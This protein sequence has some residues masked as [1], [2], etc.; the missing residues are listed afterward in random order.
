[1]NN[2]AESIPGIDH[3]DQFEEALKKRLDARLS[4]LATH[5]AAVIVR[6]Y[7]DLLSDYREMGMPWEV[8]AEELAA[9]GCLITAQSLRTTF[10]RAKKAAGQRARLAVVS[11]NIAP[12]APPAQSGGGQG[13]V[14]A[15]AKVPATPSSPVADPQ[16]EGAQAV[17]HELSEKEK[18]DLIFETIPPPDREW[19]ELVNLRLWKDE[20]GKTWDVVK[21]DRN[22][23]TDLGFKR[24][25]LF[26]ANTRR[27]LLEEWGLGVFLS[28]AS[29]KLRYT[30]SEKPELTVDLDKLLERIR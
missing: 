19:P 12:I 18:I 27:K 17:A 9:L 30:L 10:G 21:A 6:R 29:F 7:F 8:I 4:K 3:G 2:I 28:D 16:R 11:S 22:A 23:P 26:Y 24:Q 5:N 1:M 25:S 15:L 14:G 13:E 20:N